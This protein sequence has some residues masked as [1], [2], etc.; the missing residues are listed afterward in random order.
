MNV[1]VID[2]VNVNENVTVN[3]NK[4]VNVNVIV[5]VK[6]AQAPMPGRDVRAPHLIEKC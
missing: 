5:N 2:N 6:G 3:L 4:N 1:N